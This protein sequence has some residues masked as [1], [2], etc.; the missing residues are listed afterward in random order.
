MANIDDVTDETFEEFVIQ[1]KLPVV[2]DFGADWCHPCKQLDPIIDEL[3][4]EWADQVR[5]LKIDSDVNVDTTM[6]FGVM[7]L[8]TLILFIQGE[9]KD[10]L[11]GY[12]SKKKIVSTFQPHIGRE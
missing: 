10:R 1:S 9:A 7:G 3:A 8:P 5:F 6:K 12:Q 4:E 2:V 11:T